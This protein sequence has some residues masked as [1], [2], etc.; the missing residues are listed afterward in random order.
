MP[1][2][3][4]QSVL[5]WLQASGSATVRDGLERFAIPS[6][7]AYGVSVGDLRKKAKEL[8]SDHALATALWDSGRYEARMLATMVDDPAQ[9][10]IAQMDRWCAQFDNWA[11]CDT[12]C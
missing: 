7:G 9:V 10:G 5:D 1:A 8:G 4:L 11:V 6:A 2:A 3:R 12:A